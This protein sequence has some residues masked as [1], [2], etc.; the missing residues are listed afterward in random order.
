METWCEKRKNLWERGYQ[1]RRERDTHT[2]I[3]TLS[4]IHILSRH[5]RF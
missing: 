3:H 2:C 4:H 5:D 1:E